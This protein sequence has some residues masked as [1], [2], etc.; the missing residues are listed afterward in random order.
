MDTL[1]KKIIKQIVSN[2][3]RIRDVART[4]LAIVRTVLAIVFK[5][6]QAA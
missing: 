4:V 6:K 1:Y 2:G 3:K 5:T